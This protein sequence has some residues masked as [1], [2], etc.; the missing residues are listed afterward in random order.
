MRLHLVALAA[1]SLSFA[2]APLPRKPTTDRELIQG[3]W[4]AVS[5]EDDGRKE[6]WQDVKALH[7]TFS[8]IRFRISVVMHGEEHF[9]EWDF[10][11]DAL[12]RPKE[13]DCGPRTARMLY[14][15]ERNTLTVCWSNDDRFRP[16]QFTGKAGSG[17]ALVV[18]RRVR[19]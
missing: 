19:R 18:F 12:A 11:L 17:C 16:T 6:D 15:I 8:G 9:D 14:R 2:P 1:L 7:L 13:I 10:A 3:T 5:I 4:A